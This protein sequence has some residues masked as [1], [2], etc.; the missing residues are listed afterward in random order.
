MD[1]SAG[2][3]IYDTQG[4]PRL[5]SAYGTEAVVIAADIKTLLRQRTN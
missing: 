4:R 5:F 1:H 2:K 3:Y